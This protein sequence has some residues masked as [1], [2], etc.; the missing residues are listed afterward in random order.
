MREVPI[1]AAAGVALPTNCMKIDNLAGPPGGKA[2]TDDGERTDR[3]SDPIAVMA[4]I[5]RAILYKNVLVGSEGVAAT[6]VADGTV[7]QRV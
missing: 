3:Q 1:M 4:G 7:L 6:R 5:A 2:G